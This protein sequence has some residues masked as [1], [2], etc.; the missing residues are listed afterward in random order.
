M[1]RVFQQMYHI[2]GV[3]NNLVKLLRFPSFE[4]NAM[5]INHMTTRLLSL[6]S[7]PTRINKS[8]NTAGHSRGGHA[9]ATA[10]E[11]T[12]RSLLVVELVHSFSLCI[13]TRGSLSRSN[14]AFQNAS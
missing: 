12:E 1:K 14:L 4:K 9:I 5:I 13:T 7:L 6:Y 11:D 2:I 10:G 3:I 8:G